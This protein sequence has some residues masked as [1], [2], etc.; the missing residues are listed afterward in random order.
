VAQTLF[1]SRA[2]GDHSDNSDVDLLLVTTDQYT[3]HSEVAGV[4]VSSYPLVDLRQKASTGDLF[5]Y[6]V[7]FEGR[8]LYDP[9]KHLDMLKKA[10]RLRSDYSLEIRKAV[11]LGWFLVHHHS[12]V[13]KQSIVGRRAAWVVR[14]IMIAKSAEHGQPV[15]S[16][17][18]LSK[19]APSADVESLIAA[20]D[21]TDL[22]DQ[23]LEKLRSFLSLYDEQATDREVPTLR[24]YIN[25]FK[26]TDN[27]VALQLLADK[28]TGRRGH[29]E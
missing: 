24:W 15:F 8:P 14:T 2:R 23:T 10:F 12:S 9:D 6:H 4:S 19:A 7:L 26:R 28:G 1:G 13:P 3:F 20:K 21:T 27:V 11:D 29:Y 25:R 17:S 16:R 5:L 22:D 18:A